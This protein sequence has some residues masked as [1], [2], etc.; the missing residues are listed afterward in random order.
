MWRGT[1]HVVCLIVKYG[2]E[3]IVMIN[4]DLLD[5]FELTE[6]YRGIC[7]PL[8]HASHEWLNEIFDNITIHG[9]TIQFS[10]D[11][12]MYSNTVVSIDMR[13]ANDNSAA[14]LYVSCYSKGTGI[15]EQ[16]TF[17]NVSR[18]F[19][20][21]GPTSIVA[22]GGSVEFK[23][24]F[25]DKITLTHLRNLLTVKYKLKKNEILDARPEDDKCD[26]WT[27]TVIS[28]AQDKLQKEDYND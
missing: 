26:I 23:L 25:D 3:G 7:N 4:I 10:K 12:K 2:K 15:S 27:V 11:E 22:V 21:M 20:A 6:Y 19:E 14:E 1:S 8:Q 16:F 9:N 18:Y 24:C 28:S 17:N 13:W 5:K